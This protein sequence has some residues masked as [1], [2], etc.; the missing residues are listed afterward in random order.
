MC[1]YVWVEGGGLAQNC[2]TEC[3]AIWPPWCAR[4]PRSDRCHEQRKSRPPCS[5]R[6]YAPT[7]KVTE[8]WHHSPPLLHRDPRGRCDSSRQYPPGWDE[9]QHCEWHRER[10]PACRHW[11][12]SCRPVLHA[13]DTQRQLDRIA[14]GGTGEAMISALPFY[15]PSR[16]N[17]PRC[18][19]RQPDYERCSR[20]LS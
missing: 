15:I 18:P 10:V 6:Q 5:Y 17:W 3:P 11:Q 19:H 7:W 16:G 13:A 4:N 12:V 9:R 8:I 1:L 14:T 2:L 20:P